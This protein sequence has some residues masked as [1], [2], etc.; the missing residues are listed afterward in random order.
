M[1]MMFVAIGL[2]FSS[3]TRNQIV[4]AIWTF[5]VLFL[6]IVMVPLV[7]RFAARQHAGWAEA[8]RF[9]SILHQVRSFGV[10]Q[11]D[12]RHL[13]LHLSVCVLMLSLTVKV[14][15]ARANR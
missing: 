15:E 1:G 3:M 6:M 10:G 9:S 2:F 11:L 4:A 12:L 5:V 13:A 7:L 8:V 14:L